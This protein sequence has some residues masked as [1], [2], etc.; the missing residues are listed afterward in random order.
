MSGSLLGK[1]Q[2]T[3]VNVAYHAIYTHIKTLVEF[4][5]TPIE[6][7]HVHFL[8]DCHDTTELYN[9]FKEL[10]F[11]SPLEK[12]AL[13][14]AATFDVL[15]KKEPLKEKAVP[16]DNAGV[17]KVAGPVPLTVYSPPQFKLNVATTGTP[18]VVVPPTPP[19][20][21]HTP[22]VQPQVQQPIKL[23]IATV[24]DHQGK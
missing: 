2:I 5:T 24:E 8:L 18:P 15:L 13:V 20:E 11:L 14:R 6:M 19:T 12:K 16:T 17:A 7:M 22:I 9:I 1:D 21:A 3:K 10:S 4:A 23:N